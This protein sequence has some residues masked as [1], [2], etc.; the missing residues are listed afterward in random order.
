MRRVSEERRGSTGGE[1]CEEGP[2][3]AGVD[4]ACEDGLS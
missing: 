1:A 2:G 4:R 3:G